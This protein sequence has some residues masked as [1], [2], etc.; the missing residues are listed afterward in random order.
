MAIGA[1]PG[2]VFGLILRQGFVTAG[3]GLAVGLTAAFVCVRLLRSVVTGLD[4][5]DPAAIWIAAGLV[6]A[7][8]VLACWFPARRAVRT[9]PV[10]ALRHD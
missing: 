8:A 6:T 3:I 2:D 4:H 9:D 7:T 5:A 1:T 10:A